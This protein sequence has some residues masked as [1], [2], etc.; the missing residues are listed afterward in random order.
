MNTS[1]PP[2]FW[3]R[4]V[5]ILQNYSQSFLRGVGVTMAIAVVSTAVG[6]LIGFFIGIILTIPEDNKKKFSFKN[7]L[8]KT[9]KF[10]LNAYVEIFRGTPMMVQA[11]FIYYGLALLFDIHMGMWDA[12]FLIVSI[13]TGAYMAET[14]RGGIISVDSG[15]TEGAKVIGMNHFQT[16][17]YVIMPQALRNIMPQIGNN[18]IINIKDSCVLSVIGTIELFY[19][20]KGV[21]GAYYTY[22]EAFTITMVIYFVLTFICS[23][24]LRYIEN[25]MDGD[26]SYELV[27]KDHLVLT[28]GTFKYKNNKALSANRNNDTRGGF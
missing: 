25:K 4:I 16:M 26:G 2:D 27:N 19:V 23:K 22:F 1:L 5:Y 20:T 12:A 18:L 10:I 17:F 9:I 14:F 28:S 24:I 7:I 8:L 3:G 15:Q 21:A 13:N 6:C 11:M